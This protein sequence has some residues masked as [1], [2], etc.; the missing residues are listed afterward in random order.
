[1]QRI[2]QAY[3]ILAEDTRYVYDWV[4]TNEEIADAWVRTELAYTANA[5]ESLAQDVWQA[6]IEQTAKDNQ[7][8]ICQATQLARVNDALAFLG[9]ANTA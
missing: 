7:C 9:K 3:H 1:M 6:I 8:Q 5:Y 2:E 4:N